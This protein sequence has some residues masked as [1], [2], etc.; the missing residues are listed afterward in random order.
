M[1]WDFFFFQQP[2]ALRLKCWQQICCSLHKITSSRWGRERIVR[3]KQCSPFHNLWKTH[4]F[5][6]SPPCPFSQWKSLMRQKRCWKKSVNYV[7]LCD[8][9]LL[10]TVRPPTALLM[11]ACH[12][13]LR[14]HPLLFRAASAAFSNDTTSRPLVHSS[15]TGC[16]SVQFP[17]T[18][19]P[20]ENVV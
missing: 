10:K 14:G 11:L 3:E 12:V 1:C 7:E 5:W 16:Q 9:C 2:K 15:T 13:G 20:H 19:P 17:V 4:S 8:F 18:C 6:R